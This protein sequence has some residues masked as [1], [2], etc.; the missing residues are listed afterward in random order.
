MM[1]RDHI[2]GNQ[3]IPGAHE[4]FAMGIK[5]TE[6]VRLSVVGAVGNLFKS[7][8]DK[9]GVDFGCAH[10]NDIKAWLGC[11]DGEIVVR[12]VDDAF[13]SVQ[14]GDELVLQMQTFQILDGGCFPQVEATRILGRGY[15][16][17][18][19][20]GTQ[21]ENT[22]AGDFEIAIRCLVMK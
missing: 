21:S 2:E 13:Q 19:D 4:V 8:R 5:D 14:P 12:L 3:V 6:I 10:R 7:T 17:K 9:P 22:V 18:F 15:Q 20:A 16:R 11:D 1:T